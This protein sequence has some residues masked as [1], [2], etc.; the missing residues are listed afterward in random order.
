MAPAYGKMVACLQHAERRLELPR[1]QDCATTV[2]GLQHAV[3]SLELLVRVR[4]NV[5]LT[6]RA[7]WL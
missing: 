6:V 2:A 3:H 1:L 5:R 4:A 7:R